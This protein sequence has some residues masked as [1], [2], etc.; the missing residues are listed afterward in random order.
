MH[1][2]RSLQ[3]DSEQYCLLSCF[4]LGSYI[5]SNLLLPHGMG[6]PG[7]QQTPA[8]GLHLTKAITGALPAEVRAVSRAPVG[9]C[10]AG[11]VLR[12][13]QPSWSCLREVMAG[14]T[15]WPRVALQPFLQ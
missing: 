4:L 3:V 5:P 2:Y 9:G 11:M 7:R 10:R 1:S 15:T 6:W 14:L 8:A 13:L 12:V